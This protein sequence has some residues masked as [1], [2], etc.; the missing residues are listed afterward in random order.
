MRWLITQLIQKIGNWLLLSEDSQQ[1]NLGSEDPAAQ[2]Y[3]E[4]GGVV[5]CTPHVMQIMS[6]S[7]KSDGSTLKGT[8][9]GITF[10]PPCVR[11]IE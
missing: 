4:S 8:R 7:R 5:K 3:V 11:G 6:Y 2:F 10:F 9:K 1:S